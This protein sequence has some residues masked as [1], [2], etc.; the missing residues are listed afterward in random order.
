MTLRGYF[1]LKAIIMQQI[2]R[3]LVY[4]HEN[5][6]CHRDLKP[7]NFLLMKKGPIRGHLIVSGKAMEMKSVSRAQTTP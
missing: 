3:A 2:F 5:G 4:L 7:E 6:V 1:I